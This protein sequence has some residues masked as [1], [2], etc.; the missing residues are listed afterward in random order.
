[1]AVEVVVETEPQKASAF[2][3]SRTSKKWFV[4]KVTRFDTLVRRLFEQSVNQLDSRW[5]STDRTCSVC[6][7]VNRAKLTNRDGSLSNSAQAMKHEKGR[8]A[9]CHQN[10]HRR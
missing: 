3:D 2:D 8:V 7:L 5:S 10:R 9:E 4:G 1:V 6:S